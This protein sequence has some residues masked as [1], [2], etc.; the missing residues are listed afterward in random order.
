VADVEGWPVVLPPLVL[1]AGCVELTDGSVGATLVVPPPELLP[2][3]PPV[4]AEGVDGD[5][6][7]GAPVVVGFTT[8]AW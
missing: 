6:V 2:P 3:L 8:N 5:D 1:P 4:V 7:L